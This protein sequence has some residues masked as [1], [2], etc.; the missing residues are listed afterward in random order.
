MLAPAL[1]DVQAVFIAQQGNLDQLK[2]QLTA[3]DQAVNWA[4][5][6]VQ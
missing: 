3:A 5:K 1:A 4:H 6:E 2:Q